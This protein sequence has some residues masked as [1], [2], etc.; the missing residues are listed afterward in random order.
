MSKR[1]TCTSCDFVVDYHFKGRQPPFAKCIMLLEDCYIMKDPFS[2]SGGFVTVGGSCS[3]CSKDVCL[4]ADCSLFYTQRFCLTCA[5][6]NQQEFPKQIQE[7]I[8]HRAK[9]RD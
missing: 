7:E 3:L 4:S 1:F 2:T 5:H 8:L 9:L 6:R